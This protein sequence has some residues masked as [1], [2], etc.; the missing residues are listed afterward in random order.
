MLTN[1]FDRIKGMIKKLLIFLVSFTIIVTLAIFYRY[2]SNFPSIIPYPY[3][4]SYRINKAELEKAQNSQVLIIGDEQGLELNRYFDELV[5]DLSVNINGDLKIYNWSKA[6]EP[7]VRTIFKL[8]SLSK[9]PPLIIYF[10]GSSEWDEQKFF[11]K[12]IKT[13]EKNLKLYKDENII[14]AMMVFSPLARLIYTPYKGFHIKKDPVTFKAKKLKA[15]Y[16]QKRMETS[17]KIFSLEVKELSSFLQKSDAQFIYISPALNLEKTPSTTCQNSTN[18]KLNYYI[19]RTISLIEQKN[20]KLA[21]KDLEKM[22]DTVIGNSL[23]HHAYGKALLGIGKTKSSKIHFTKSIALDCFPKGSSPIF[24]NI[25]HAEMKRSA[26]IIVD[27]DN[28]V[29]SQLGENILFSNTKVAQEIFYDKLVSELKIV[30][31]KALDI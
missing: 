7:L 18:E 13:F 11:F 14:S 20:Y 2:K 4:I 16:S 25:F 15:T 27:F 3:K 31:A 24:N 22:D 26:K 8:K 5:K 21:L 1:I 28:I 23:F 29:N 10:G 17:F 19:K 30:I 6:K 12:D 9:L